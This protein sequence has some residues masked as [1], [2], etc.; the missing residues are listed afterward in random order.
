MTPRRNPR[1]R[2]FLILLAALVGFFAAGAPG[3]EAGNRYYWWWFR[4][5]ATTTT[6]T[7]WRQATTTTTAAPTTTTAP[8]TTAAPTTTTTVRPTTTTTLATTT[9]TAPQPSGVTCTCSTSS[10]YNVTS[11]QSITLTDASRGRTLTVYYQRPNATGRFPLVIVGHGLGGNGSQAMTNTRWLAQRGYV[12]VA[13]TFP[14][15]SQGSTSGLN[16]QPGD[17]S[18]VLTSMLASNSPV[19]AN[20]DPERLGYFGTSFGGMT[21]TLFWNSAYDDPRFDAY[22]LRMGAPTSQSSAWIY[23]LG[24]PVLMV[25]GDQDTVV[26]YSEGHAFYDKVVGRKAFITLKGVGHDMTGSPGVLSQDA[27][28]AWFDQYLKGDAN[29][30]ARIRQAVAANSSFAVLEEA[31]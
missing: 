16:K 24:K 28:L 22:G 21:G 10:S 30:S 7:T 17:V 6:S 4:K 8:P 13:P 31:G 27:S 1:S 15:A 23:N 19:A 5:P 29:G 18:F 14:E 3:A 26:R 2:L 9:T 11:P 12:V 25:H 20:I